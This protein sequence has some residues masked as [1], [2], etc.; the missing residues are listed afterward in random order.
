MLTREMLRWF[1]FGSSGDVKMVS[2]WFLGRCKSTWFGIGSSGD[3]CFC[4]D[5]LS[6]GDFYRC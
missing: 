2:F 3:A 6:G 1:A 5:A 4:V